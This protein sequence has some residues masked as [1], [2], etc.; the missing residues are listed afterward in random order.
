[1]RPIN[2][3][4]ARPTAPPK[5]S[6]HPTEQTN[7]GKK[8]T[9]RSYVRYRILPSLVF[10]RSPTGIVIIVRPTPCPRLRRKPALL[11]LVRSAPLT[12][13]SATLLIGVR[14]GH[15]QARADK[16]TAPR[17]ARQV[18]LADLALPQQISAQALGQLG[19]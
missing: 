7:I 19:R 17:A 6:V 9:V 16:A 18:Q 5:H 1:M 15:L 4:P 3:R 12:L 13:A 11:L 10:N 14:S 8:E 2:E